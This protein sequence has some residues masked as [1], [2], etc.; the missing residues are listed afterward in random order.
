MQT[1]M[2]SWQQAIL[3]SKEKPLLL[4]AAEAGNAELMILGCTE[5]QASGIVHPSYASERV[6][7]LEHDARSVFLQYGADINIKDE[8]SGQ[9]A[10]HKA[11][12]IP[13]P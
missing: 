9:T 6:L 2:R 11:S 3:N 8:A 5:C 13:G 4:K 1:D 12:R 10:L 7:S